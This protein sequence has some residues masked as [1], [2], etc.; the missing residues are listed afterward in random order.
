[1]LKLI[2]ALAGLVVAGCSRPNGQTSRLAITFPQSSISSSQISQSVGALTSSSKW[3]LSI[4]STSS[5][6]NCYAVAVAAPT[7]NGHVCTNLSGAT[8]MQ[9]GTILGTFPAGSTQVLEVAPGNQRT[10]YLIGF[11]ASNI[12]DCKSIDGTALSSLSPSTFSAPSILDQVTMNLVPGNVNVTLNVPA[13][14]GSTTPFEDCT[15]YS[16]GAAA[17]TALTVTAVSPTSGT[18]AGGTVVSVTGTGFDGSTS[19]EI[20]LPHVLL[21]LTR[22]PRLRAQQQPHPAELTMSMSCVQLK[23]PHFLPHLL[24]ERPHHF[25]F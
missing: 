21:V 8:V 15:P 2:L 3:G 23:L 17:S 16:F 13:S 7:G 20:G 14:M 9:P 19:V 22:A 4:P 24:M 1:M 5:Q 25:H 6:L 18:T 10:I 12:N 11:K